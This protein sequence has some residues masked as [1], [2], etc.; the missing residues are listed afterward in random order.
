MFNCYIFRLRNLSKRV[1]YHKNMSTFIQY[2]L[3]L[4]KLEKNKKTATNFVA[5]FRFCYFE[6]FL[7]LVDEEVDLERVDLPRGS[8]P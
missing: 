7:F 5:V 2:R 1:N 6:L 4:K 8:F 3:I